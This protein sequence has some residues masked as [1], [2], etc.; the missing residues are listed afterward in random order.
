MEP[1]RSTRNPRVAQAVRLHR[2]RERRKTGLTLLEGPNLV[3]EALAAG[4]RPR[5]VFGTGEPPTGL[6]PGAWVPVTA[7]VLERLA[8]TA[9]PR[10]PIAVVEV[11][12]AQPVRRDHLLLDVTDP[13]NAGTLI[14]TAAAFGMDVALR[15]GAVDP[16]SPKVT[17]SAAGAHFR[18]T[19]GLPLP[20][21]GRIVA[22]AV[23]G[24]PS[25]LFTG[26]LDRERRWAVH[27]GSEAHGVSTADA[28]SADI[29]V[30]IPMPG[31][32]ESL[33]AAVAGG[34]LAYELMTWRGAAGAPSRNR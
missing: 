14:R 29:R 12:D 15:P 10:G 28:D 32:V 8:E 2:V 30:T 21:A 16:W 7:E 19:V 34:I 5:V 31:G 24:V 18:T 22:V 11:P 4:V 13:G 9:T 3:A 17:R 27:I 25:P 23:G 1:V 20:G 6:D 33:N 26:R